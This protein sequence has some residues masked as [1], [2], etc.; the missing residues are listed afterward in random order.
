VS[1]LYLDA[2][3]I[4]YLIEASSPLHGIV[5]HRL[6]THRA[7]PKAVLLTSRLSRLESR[8]KPLRDADTKLLL[9]YEVFFSAHR[10][11]IV[12][13]SAA[14]VEQATD[15]CAR[16]GFK[17]PDS[18]HLATAIVA[19]ADVFLTGDSALSKCPEVNVEVVA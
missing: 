4:I 9:N 17:T 15:L 7:D 18:L 13:L 10:L 5:A 12:E 2:C 16:Y 19:Q 8:V 11:F 3:C 6:L 14:V 1:R